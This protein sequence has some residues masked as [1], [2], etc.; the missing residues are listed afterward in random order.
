MS[1]S[2]NLD[3]NDFFEEDLDLLDALLSDDVR[4]KEPA[5]ATQAVNKGP[6]SFQQERLWFLSE[7]DPD[8]A[9]YTIFN[10]F[11]LQGQLDEKALFAALETLV[12]RH[13][14]L[15][16]AIC[17]QDGQA[18]QVIMPAY[19]PVQNSVDLTQTEGE[20]AE[21]ALHKLL[22]SEAARPF[23]LSDGK[24]FRVVLAKL[25]ADEHA[26]MLS[27]HHIISDAWS[28]TVL[29]GELA[30][31]YHAY[32]R[33]EEP[34]LPRRSLRYIDYALWQRGSTAAKDRESRE[35][36]YWLQ[37]LE[38]LPLLELPTDFPRPQ[39]QTFNGATVSFQLPATTTHALQKLS[40][41]ER[42]TL[43]SLLMA[44][45]HVLMARH[46][47]QSDVAIGTS[48]AGRDDQALEGLIGFFANMVVIR[49]RL[50]QDPSFR[51]L[52]RTTAAKVH[53]AMDHST[54]AYDRL[55]EGMKIA[56][57]PSRNPIFQ[58][59]MT[60]L[61]LP[62]SRMSLGTLAAE[63]LLSQEAARFDLELFLSESDGILAGTFVYNTDLFLPASLNRLTEQWLILLAD[64]AA[65]PDKPVSQLALINDSAA[66]LPFPRQTSPAAVRP[67]HER[68]VQQA[69]KWPDRRA[70]QLGNERL[71]YGELASQARQIAHA[72]I[73]AGI[74]TEQPVGLWFEPGF[75]MIAAMLGT[76]MAGGGY[77]PVDIHSPAERI[78]TIIEDSEVKFM[79]SDS[80]HSG[81]IPIFAGTLL[82]I[83]EID[84][85]PQCD[86]PE[87]SPERLAYIIYTSGSTGRPKGVEVTH[88]N[89]ARL[90]S[91]CDSLFEFERSDVWTF[92]HSYAFDF[93]VW[94]IWGALVHGASLLIVPPIVARSTDS[95]YDLLCDQKVTV[96][97]Q[98][99]SAFRQLMAAEEA[100][101]REGDLALRYVVF[102]GEALDIAS[103]ASWMDRHGDEE[104]R[105]VNMYGI[106]EITVHATFRLI[107][108]ADLPRA[109]SSVIGTPLPDL[110]LRLLDPNGE[111][112][113]EGMVGEIFVGGAGVARGYRNQP[114]LTAARFL[115]DA[116]GMPLYR[117]GDLARI[118]AWGELEYRGRAD[119]Q[120]KL[121][122]YRIE[123]GEIENTLRRHPAIEDAVVAVRGQN[124]AARLV[125]W[126]RKRPTSLPQGGPTA[127]D[128]RPSFD[129]IYAAEVE[130]DDLDVVGWNDSYDNKPLPLEHMRL[131]RDEI[132]QRLRALQPTRVLE[133]GTGSGMLLLPLAEEVERYQGLDFSA[134]AV[135][136]LSRKVAG[137]G[138]T[139]V[140]L[141]QREASDQ[142]GLPDDFDLAILNSIA[143]YFPKASYFIDVLDQAMQRLNASGS[144]FVGDLR[145]LGLLRHFHASRL[146]H[147]RPAESDRASLLAQLTKMVE[148]E[149]ELLVDPAFFF[150]WAAQRDDIARIDI[151]PKVGGGQNE[152][153]TYRYDVAI[154][155]GTPQPSQ[156]CE[157]IDVANIHAA[158]QGQPAFISGI[159][160]PRLAAVD[161]FLGWLESDAD[162]AP[163]SQQWNNWSSAEAGQAPGVLAEQWQS[164][165]GAAKLYW[166]VEGQPGHFELAVA[167][168]IEALPALAPSVTID[169]ELTQFFNVPSK[170]REEEPLATTL[171][172][173]LAA[174]LPDYMLP[175]VYI[176]LETFPLTLNGKL[177]Y[178]ALPEPEEVQEVTADRHQHFNDTERKVAKIWTEVLQLAQPE[179]HANFFEKGGHSLLATQVI[180]RLNAAFSVKL[181]LR[182]LFDHPTIAGLAA[183]LESLLKK[184]RQ[185]LPPSAD[186]KAVPRG[187]L[188]PLAYTQ[189]RFWFMEQIDR[190]SIG[191]H[192]I[193]LA[194]RL[195]GQ[196]VPAALRA[197][198]QTVVARHEALRTVFVQNEGEP[199]QLIKSDWTPETEET[200]LSHL[201]PSEAE[202]A[203]R[204]RI[205]V[206]ANT[207]F[208]LDVAPPLR[209]DLVR[210]S[211][212]EHVLQLTLHHAICDGW[213]LGVMVREF[214]ECYAASVA[215]R[216]PQLP[217][218]PLQL[219]D[220][221]VWQRTE[222]AGARLQSLLQQ[223]KQ[224]LLGAPYGLSLPFDRVPPSDVPKMGQIIYF[225]FD[226]AQ[227][228]QLKHFAESQGATLFMVLTAGYSALLSRYSGTYDVVIGTPIAQ[229]QHKEL[230]GIVGCF[231]NTLALRIQSDAGISGRALLA[232]VRERVL[233]AYEWQDAPFDAVVSEL[234]PE[235]SRDR[236]ALFQTMLTL[237][238]MPL[239]KFTLPGL[240][241]EPLQGEEGVA[242]FDLS[243]TFIETADDNGQSGLQGMLE[244]DANKFLHASVERFSTQLHSLLLAMAT[245]PET[246]VATL[247]L[248]APGEREHLLEVLNETD[249]AI[250]HER[251]LHELIALQAA[252]TPDSIAVRDATGEI[253]Y[254]E[255][256]ARANAVAWAL[257]EHGVGPDSIVGL[258]T[259][260][261][262]GMV[263]GLLGIMKAGA[264]Y[265]PLDPD[266][267]AG[268]LDLILNDARP[269]VLVTQSGLTSA[270]SFSGPKI[271]L[272]DL[273]LADP[274]PASGVMPANL[275]YII[276]TSGS[277]GVPKGVMITHAA[278]VNYLSW[279]L[280]TYTPGSEGT[281]LMSPSYAFDGSMTTLF[282]P[283]ISG[284]CMQLML[285]D[286]V[287][288]R[289]RYALLARSEQLALIDCG[290][291]QL[292]VLQQVLEPEQ[293]AS[294]RVEAIV[295][296]GEALQ[297]STV[298]QWRRHAPS[299]RLYNEYGPTEATV[300]CCTYQ[301][302]A[303]SP[304]FGP[305]PVGR[306]IWNVRVYVLDEQ[307]QPVPPGI[308]GD[309]YVAGSGLARGYA[310]KPG[311]TAQSFIPDP[312]SVGG[313]LYRTGDR[314][315]WSTTG[316][317]NYLGRND[318]QVKFR[319]FRIE[320]GEIEEKIRQYPGVTEAAVRVHTDDRGNNSLVAYLAEQHDGL[321]HDLAAWLRERLPGF[322]VPSHYVRLDALPIS[323]SGKVDRNALPLPDN[324]GNSEAEKRETRA[325]NAIEQRLATIWREVTGHAVNDPEADFFEA[326]GDSL[327]A[328]KL[329][330]LIE[331]EFKRALPLASL[332][333]LRTLEAQAVAITA[334]VNTPTDVLVPIHV[335]ENAPSVV[336][337]HDISGQILS[338]RPLAE[339]L[340]AFSVYAI[341]SL[342]AQHENAPSIAQM[343][344]LYARAIVEANIP[345]PL[346]LA[347]HSFGAQ[348]A[349]ELARTLTAQGKPPLL[350]AILD[351]IA[352]PDRA[353]LDQLPRDDLDLMDYMI[354]TIEL[355]IEKRID[356][357]ATR[358]RALPEAKRAG[359][360]TAKITEAGVVPEQTSPEH[361]MQL[362]TIYKN[363]LESLHGYQPGRV[364]CPVALW[365]TEALYPQ[366]EAG[367]GNY[368]D[369]VTVQLA[370]GD[371]VSMLKPPHVQ[372]L[373]ASL[374]Q[375]INDEMPS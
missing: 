68:I 117:S 92:F 266:Y 359:W 53:A 323:V 296:G 118:N 373:A 107:T 78:A 23:V 104:P 288:S 26:L 311:L 7:L 48:I 127:E 284:R 79:L 227:L 70:L 312:F 172:R 17:S 239:G 271:L 94:E 245:T 103:L 75:G 370:S 144:L 295:I 136:R 163:T 256:E 51:T 234:S 319:G 217:A 168:R 167:T 277:T 356:L 126:V 159:P 325:L 73:A 200:D 175:A 211:E 283:L 40:A 262:R 38:G 120:I 15:R 306:G 183:M 119:S 278:I 148:G 268:R 147:R 55:V 287:L 158:W 369:R 232:H 91:S 244:Y 93:S 321:T 186:L 344:E 247:D 25:A 115:R 291:A 213:S 221:A 149:K 328:V 176:P 255:L 252:R 350:L 242:G 203:L 14:A 77:M 292:D 105:L 315:S 275:A 340:K 302:T 209:L 191:S 61:N 204:E 20:A 371:H 64:I 162:A 260:R 65:S 72:L 236:H 2:G 240:E 246:P 98:T 346:I 129:M 351:G 18:Q 46:A 219:A 352:E 71:T 214:S 1:V 35:M 290:P 343:A 152:L 101:P 316:V 22:R 130:D 258:C 131:W 216:A 63:K 174:Y 193:S 345:G 3:Q 299:T 161:A 113:P 372:G 282:T 34:L 123:T 210:L 88:A 50:E 347:G 196:L 201:S 228:R 19:M 339:Q 301:I 84:N 317:I 334:E 279:A 116:S 160:N 197:A 318:D 289:T 57:D 134:E 124:D 150:H 342:A 44:A 324:I 106:T 298:E 249:H 95:F 332:F 322:M 331:R 310:G 32:A 110:C 241:A 67:L 132:L 24:P 223:W 206:Q 31:I 363:N 365:S 238:N 358:L 30:V 195:R 86:L 89:A 96:L 128:W 21:Q 220:F 237:Q 166:T 326:G 177:N 151:L 281:V 142:A 320:L 276:Y 355:S 353:S 293:L 309:L 314:A 82:C 165:A 47:R 171:R 233:E 336:L 80:A 4:V 280:E 257:H 261:D 170:L 49:A 102:G 41:S 36:A 11:R 66:L 137:R 164:R 329:I 140:Q 8:A 254:A 59:A 307:M 135:A 99:P 286:E 360:I 39:K 108:Y 348:V 218:L 188:L 10:A 187:G 366:G 141:E 12:E 155:K 90:F 335:R 74:N 251:C 362:F 375:A 337:V 45:L 122:G 16:T 349:T 304:W 250:P 215:G 58:V 207:R 179:L 267:P 54:L 308:A 125:A 367:W 205:A 224:R 27:L 156:P 199:A 83:D 146:V 69:E 112:V 198:I 222:L 364:T 178:S 313:R 374:A 181:P 182:S 81:T 184:T 138:F 330:F 169:A 29:M 109:A 300:G 264:A 225:N 52:L 145:H 37:E 208:K 76:W 143:Q 43:F 357:D 361:V 133:L 327:R 62:G 248:L 294:S 9:A 303:A 263:I 243:V 100:N 173:Y 114:A 368:A 194:L 192:N 202:K 180:S 272:E 231:L 111:P 226:A 259:E 229:R 13:E 56:R 338:Y 6:L 230:E 185:S 305:M 154:L 341:Q 121:R 354:R 139:H 42:T 157:R 212:Q 5:I 235:R 270:T 273:G 333:G 285:R 87:V 33:G 269:A 97:S 60:L 297:A 253:S 153:T 265:L 28:M 85:P 274:C 189:Q 190:G